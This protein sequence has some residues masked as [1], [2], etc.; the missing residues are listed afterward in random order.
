MKIK[1]IGKTPTVRTLLNMSYN[2]RHRLDT[3][4]FVQ[5]QCVTWDHVDSQ[6]ERYRL[7]FVPGLDG[8]KCSDKISETW[9]GIMKYY[10]ELM[11]KED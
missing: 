10:N 5:M 4:A 7:S 8:S 6:E 1:R 11:A 2:L 9:T 3:T